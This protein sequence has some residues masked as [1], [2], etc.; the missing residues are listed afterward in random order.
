MNTQII[1]PIILSGGSG[2]R[3]WPLSRRSMPKQFANLFEKL[4]LFQN[5]VERLNHQIF[6]QPIIITGE[7]SRFIAKRQLEKIKNLSATII[8]EPEPKDT[9]AAAIAGII[10]SKK[11]MHDP[12]VLILPADHWIENKSYFANLMNRATKG[13]TRENILTF[14]IKPTFPHTGYGWI[15][16]DLNIENKNNNIFPVV[17]FFEKPNKNSAQEFFDDKSFFWNSGIFLG[18]ASSFLKTYHQF[19]KDILSF[20]EKSYQHLEKDLG[21][22]R[23][24]K[25]HWNKIKKISIDHAI[26]E[27]H[28]KIKM[29]PFEDNW[30]DIGS[31][32]SLMEHNTSD[33][34][35]NV[36]QGN[37]TSINCENTFLKTIDDKIHLV[38]L[39]LKNI[40]AVATN[41]AVICLENNHSED[42]RKAVD[43]LK[44]KKIEQVHNSLYDYRP[45][46]NFEI[47]S[48][49]KNFQVKKI[50]VYPNCKLSLQSHQYRSEHW[51][52][53]EGKARVTF[54]EKI[55]TLLKN[56]S[57][58]INAGI[59]HR[60]ENITKSIITIIEVQTGSYLGEDDIVRFEDDYQR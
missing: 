54:G 46:G 19:A 53:V 59:K 13:V 31:L 45:W 32:K 35:D 14:G 7:I 23:L 42:V 34:N 39:G 9:A 26:I 1:Q 52:V 12:L 3:L 15:K 18:K 22:L 6:H 27:K 44:E 16:A 29:I 56:E 41:D 10:H 50:Q 38:G 5:T 4:T 28:N 33:K 57:V 20:V 55:I 2:T 51:V 36:I 25:N 11:K 37:S 60:L 30:S 48:K 17:N 43:I 24:E 21:F 8:I 40:I 47:L 49:G 58:F